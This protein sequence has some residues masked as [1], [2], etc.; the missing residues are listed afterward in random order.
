M[1]VYEFRCPACGPFDLR[2]DMGNATDVANCPS[3][4][5]SARRHYGV[6]V[7]RPSGVLRDA[8]RADRARVD[9]ARSGEPVITGPPS[10][11]RLP[12]SSGHRH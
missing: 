1:P 4:A 3:C 6:G 9:R 11:R 5:H 2:L 12:R 10:G 7:G 8:G